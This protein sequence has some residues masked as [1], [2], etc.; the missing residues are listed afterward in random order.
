M[1]KQWR[2]CNGRRCLSVGTETKYTH[3]QKD[4]KNTTHVANAAAA[5][6]SG[7]SAPEISASGPTRVRF[8]LVYFCIVL[9]VG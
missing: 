1:Q 5:N 7:E 3:T 6:P 8:I 4:G 2:N 9:F